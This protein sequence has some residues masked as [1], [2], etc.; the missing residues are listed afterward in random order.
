MKSEILNTNRFNENLN[1]SMTYLDKTNMI[2]DH[3]IIV[4]ERFPM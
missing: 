2:R 1:L 4:E 3:K